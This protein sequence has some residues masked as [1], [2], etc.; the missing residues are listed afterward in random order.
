[1]SARI[2]NMEQVRLERA[3]HE[4]R[5]DNEALTAALAAA[6]RRADELD[7]QHAETLF[8]L[9]RTE[10]VRDEMIER[11]K[12]LQ[13]RLDELKASLPPEPRRPA[14]VLKFPAEPT[15]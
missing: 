12:W 3:L 13:G 4:A 14:E 6:T 10:T 15:P 1:M 2:E 11:C 7:A 8:T 9:R 5:Q